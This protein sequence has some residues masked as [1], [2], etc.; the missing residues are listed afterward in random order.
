MPYFAKMGHNYHVLTEW[1]DMMKEQGADTSAIEKEVT[2]YLKELTKIARDLPISDKWTEPDELDAIKKLRPKGPRTLPFD[3]TDEQ[4]Y[5]KMLGAWLGRSAGCILGIPVEG[6]SKD[7]IE[8]WAKRF[9]QPYPLAEYFKTNP[10]TRDIHY[11][12]P[13]D[14]FTRDNIDHVGPDDDLAYSVLGVLILEEYGIDFTMEDVG[15]AWVKYLPMACTAEHVALNNLK[16]GLKPPKTA[17]KDNPY[18]EW[19]GADIRSDPWGYAAPGLPE[20]AAEFAWRD[21]RVSHL[22]NGI[23]GEMF[24]SAAIAAAFVT[25]DIKEVLNIALTEI[26]AK[27]RMAQTVKET[28][29]WCETDGEWNKTHER[30]AKK[31]ERMSVAHTLNNA[32]LTVMGLLYGSGDFEKTI[33]LTVMG[34]IDTDCT[35]ATAGSIMG[36]MIGAKNLPQKWIAPLGDRLTSYLIDKGEHKVSDLARRCCEIAKKVHGSVK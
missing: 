29:K 14:N 28:I 12:E 19:I 18:A 2:Q 35:G 5:D 25:D 4:L 1:L 16:A 7:M 36:A 33:T 8:M 10:N 15:K 27:C 23:Y 17:L 6:H 22:K 32:A 9:G 30:V 3:L 34:G 31:Y 13:L 21:A 24:F 20:K 11:N 26:P